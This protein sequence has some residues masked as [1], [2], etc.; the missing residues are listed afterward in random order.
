MFGLLLGFTLS[1]CNQPLSL[2]LLNLES[3]I[4]F[5]GLVPQCQKDRTPS[6]TSAMFENE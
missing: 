2:I 5:V 6:S 4:P 1:F 3:G